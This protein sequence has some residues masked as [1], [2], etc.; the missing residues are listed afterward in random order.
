MGN[1]ST[2]L[3]ELGAALNQLNVI[4]FTYNLK[5]SFRFNRKE[6]FRL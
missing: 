4:F 1:I 2:A 6:L 5:S 3:I